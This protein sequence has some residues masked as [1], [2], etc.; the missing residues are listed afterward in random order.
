ME[1]VTGGDDLPINLKIAGLIM[2]IIASMIVAAFV[3]YN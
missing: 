2:A 3:V 1:K